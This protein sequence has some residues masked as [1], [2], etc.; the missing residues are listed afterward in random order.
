MEVVEGEF[1]V[2]ARLVFTHLKSIAEAAGG[3]MNDIT[4]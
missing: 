2:H 3:S 4:K 1:D